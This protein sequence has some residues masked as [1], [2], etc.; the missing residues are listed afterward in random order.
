MNLRVSLILLIVGSWIAIGAAWVVD[1]DFGSDDPAEEPPYFYN[2][3]V[4]DIVHIS[5]ATEGQ[6]VSFHY[7]EGIRRWYFDDTTELTETPA[8]LFRFGGIT[9]L[10]GGPRTQRF[11]NSEITDPAEYG[12]DEPSSRYTIGLRDGTERVL[13]VGDKTPNGQSTYAQVQGFPQL[14]LVDTSWSDVL[15]RLVLEPPVPEWLFD[16]NPDEVRE[17]LLFE[18]NEIVRAYG[19]NRDTGAYHLCD[20]PVQSDPCA[21]ET[22]VDEEAFRAALEHIASR[23]IDGAVALGLP[24]EDAFTPYGAGR[25]SPYMAIRIERPSPSNPNVTEVNRVSMTIGDVTPDGEHRYAVA[26][27]TSDVIIVDREWAEGVLEL[28]HGEPLTAD[29]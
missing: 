2:I 15:D 20:L 9:T 27:E 11:L 4:D 23:E 14:V 29:S 6:E 21:G 25:N 13:L 8:D 19:I 22:P 7:R 24:D 28:F 3:P 10:L 1:S 16:L 18:N 12:L 26:N 5:L 17:V